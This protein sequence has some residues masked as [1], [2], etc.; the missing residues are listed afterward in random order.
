MHLDI[1]RAD[2]D[3]DGLPDDWET[4]HFGDLSQDGTSDFDQ[5][6]LTNAEEFE[7]NTDPVVEDSDSDGLNDGDEVN[8]Y[9]SDPNNPDSDG[10]TLSDGDEVL[11]YETDPTNPDSDGHGYSDGAEITA[12]TDPNDE[13]DSPAQPVLTVT[14]A[15]RAVASSDGTCVFAVSN[16]GSGTMSWTAAVTSGD[17]WLTISSGTESGVNSGEFQA[18]FSLNTSGAVRTGTIQVTASGEAGSPKNVTVVQ[19]PPGQAILV[20]DPDNRDMGALGGTTTFDV[21]NAGANTMN[22]TAIVTPPDDSWLSITAG[23]ESGTNAD[24]I[25]VTCDANQSA[26]VRVGTIR[27]EATGAV[28]SPTDVTVTQEPRPPTGAMLQVTP[29]NREVSR[30][31]GSTTF[32]VSNTGSGTM[33]WTASVVSSSPWLSIAPGADSGTN[34]G[35]ITAV[36][37]ENTSGTTRTGTIRVEAPGAS[38]SL[39]DVIVTQICDAPGAVTGV[40]ATDGNFP[41]KVQVTWNAVSGADGYEVY[42]AETNDQSSAASIGTVSGTVYNDTAAEAPTVTTPASGC[43]GSALPEVEYHYYYY[44]WVKAVS[45]CGSSDFSESDQ[46]YRGSDQDK[47]SKEPSVFEEALPASV[48]S[49]SARLIAASSA[50][51]VRIRAEEGIDPQSVWGTI[52]SATIESASVLWWP[53]SDSDGW[54]VYWPTSYWQPGDQV[55]M[56]VGARTESGEEIG[57]SAYE[58]QVETETQADARH[59]TEGEPVWQPSV[60]ELDARGLAQQTDANDPPNVMT[61]A[62]EDAIAALPGGVGPVFVVGPDRA[63]NGPQRVWLP[64]PADEDPADIDIYYYYHGGGSDAG[65]YRGVN[66]D[67]W[68]VP[69]ETL[70]VENNGVTYIGVLVQHGGIVQLG[71]GA[72]EQSGWTLSGVARAGDLLGDILVLAL[73]MALTAFPTRIYAARRRI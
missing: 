21:S 60:E 17:A 73:A 63:F 55:T 56:T 42:R 67:G 34:S 46:G 26:L 12:G 44:Y 2:T 15:T 71:I 25:E 4:E 8:T 32:A 51:C 66:V 16:S 57:P 72:S 39:H 13:N 54:V 64:V 6:G 7:A 14:P 36:F 33:A 1:G 50:L 47:N 41:D 62:S 5:D 9:A 31:A 37:E 61:L 35:T 70:E 30:A 11:T 45:D 19:G 27:V 48:L 3:A 49:G 22:W 24:T 10:D 28:G 53:V 52:T 58:F 65:W 43:L 18:A 23:T 69:N 68:L 59:S 29:D 40:D 20:V 38:G